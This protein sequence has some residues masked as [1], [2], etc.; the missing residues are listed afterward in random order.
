MEESLKAFVLMP[1]DSEF[2]GIYAD[3]IKPALEEAGY[4]VRRADSFLDQRNILRDIVRGIWEAKLVIAD[5]TTANPNVFYELGLCHG[6]RIPT[7]LIA[8]SME[9]VPFDLRSYR[10]LIYSTRFDEVHLL[11]T[12][13]R[14]L[15]QKARRAE[16]SFES[17]LTDFTPTQLDDRLEPAIRS[18]VQNPSIAEAPE[19]EGFLDWVVGLEEA[20]AEVEVK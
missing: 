3:L 18:V 17:P 5:L 20:G 4:E 12:S 6:L 11:K 15:G 2:K 13:L 14:E 19:E 16:I 9:Q 1:F 10:V 7:V 8:Q